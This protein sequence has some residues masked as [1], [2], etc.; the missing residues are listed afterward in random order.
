MEVRRAV[1]ACQ[2]ARA[3]VH[4][5]VGGHVRL[6]GALNV[7]QTFKVVPLDV[8]LTFH[9]ALMRM[10]G[11]VVQTMM[12]LAIL[13]SLLLVVLSRGVPRRLSAGA[14]AMAL[15]WFLVTRFGN[16]P[17]DQRI[18]VWAVTSAPRWSSC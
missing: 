14:G 10:N 15:T 2:G 7:A 11:P 9:T 4:R 5:P 1:S 12:A 3:A 6:Y 18:K 16:V 17:I 8:R 13:S